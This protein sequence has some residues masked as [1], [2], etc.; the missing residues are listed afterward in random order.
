MSLLQSMFTLDPS[1]VEKV[2][3]PIMVYVFLIAGLRL[4]G[5]RELAQMNPFDLV[6]LLTISNTVQNAIIGRDDSVTGGLIGAATLLIVNHIAVRLVYAHKRVQHIV[7]GTPTELIKSGRVVTANLEAELVTPEELEAAAL[8]QGFTSLDEIDRAILEP[9]GS[10]TFF[11]KR[12]TPD[13]ARDE[14]IMQRLDR[15]SAQLAALR[16]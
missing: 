16:A 11:H 2:L 4:A 12:P 6:V 3:R 15:I 7:E 9:G 5:K 8:K 13:E 1:V 14:A 10:M